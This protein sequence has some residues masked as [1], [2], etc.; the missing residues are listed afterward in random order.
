MVPPCASPG[1]AV[2][3]AE[4]RGGVGA[5]GDGRVVRRQGT[6]DSVD[7]TFGRR[8]RLLVHRWVHP[9]IINQSHFL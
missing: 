5:G 2:P 1:A 7:Q 8:H 6:A 4:H 3:G 9:E